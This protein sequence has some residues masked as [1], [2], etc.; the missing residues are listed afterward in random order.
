MFVRLLIT[1][2]FAFD[3]YLLVLVTFVSCWLLMQLSVSNSDYCSGS[4]FNVLRLLHLHWLSDLLVFVGYC[5]W[6]LVRRSF[7][8]WCLLVIFCGCFILFVLVVCYL[9]YVDFLCYCFV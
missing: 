4:L 2:L 3:L 5:V 1:W 9:V 8:F 7:V 6:L